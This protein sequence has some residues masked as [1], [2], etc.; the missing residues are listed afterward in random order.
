LTKLYIGQCIVDAWAK[1]S[2]SS[3]VQA[4][5]K[6]RFIPE[7][8]SNSN[9]IDL[10]DDGRNPGMLDVEIVQ[11]SNSNTKDEEFN[12]IVKFNAPYKSVHLVYENKPF[13]DCSLVLCIIIRCALKSAKYGNMILNVSLYT[14]HSCK[15]VFQ[16]MNACKFRVFYKKNL[17]TNITLYHNINKEWAA[18]NKKLEK[19]TVPYSFPWSDCKTS[20]F[21]CV[22]SFFICPTPMTSK[23]IFSGGIVLFDNTN[24]QK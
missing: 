23:T 19:I 15:I 6:V 7:Q 4:S 11:L 14:I 16:I 20:A 2:I 8:L 10:H 1:V 22:Q 9:E 18:T 3:I 24:C 5:I 13:S 21:L 17:N 12:W